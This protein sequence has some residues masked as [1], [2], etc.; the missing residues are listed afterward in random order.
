[1]IFDIPDFPDLPK[2]SSITFGAINNVLQR[3]LY[4]ISFPVTRKNLWLIS[5]STANLGQKPIT[6]VARFYSYDDCNRYVKSN[7][8]LKDAV[9]NVQN[10]FQTFHD[11]NPNPLFYRYLELNHQHVHITNI[12]N[13]G[14]K[15]FYLDYPILRLFCHPGIT[16]ATICTEFEPISHLM[17]NLKD[18]D[19]HGKP[20]PGWEK[21]LTNFPNNMER[22]I[23]MECNATD[24]L[25]LYNFISRQNPGF[26]MTVGINQKILFPEFN[27]Y[28]SKKKVKGKVGPH[29][30]PT[31]NGYYPRSI[32]KAKYPNLVRRFKR[33]AE[34]K[35]IK[36]KQATV[37]RYRFRNHKCC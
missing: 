29:L 14:G 6:F 23:M 3:R 27:K 16:W 19:Y 37:Y 20:E 5:K 30:G 25:A 9:I 35:L 18:L 7:F 2:L 33:R 17:P 12:P 36:F 32:P 4:Q 26:Y 31:L 24:I 13:Y 1:M 22:L 11:F 21:Y 28:F 10:S 15:I 8:E 34:N